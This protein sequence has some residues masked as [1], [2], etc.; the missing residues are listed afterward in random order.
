MKRRV[1]VEYI[2]GPLDGLLEDLTSVAARTEMLI[3]PSNATP[4]EGWYGA[5]QSNGKRYWHE[6]PPAWWKPEGQTPP[7][8]PPTKFPWEQSD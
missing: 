4:P 1:S 5:V 2:R 6:G 3:G 8:P 7:T